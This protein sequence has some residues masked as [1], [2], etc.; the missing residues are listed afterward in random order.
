LSD[1]DKQRLLDVRRI[2]SVH[3]ALAVETSA[4]AIGIVGQGEEN[5]RLSL[6]L[7]EKFALSGWH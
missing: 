5:L 1:R 6:E 4:A 7:C 3:H 2:N